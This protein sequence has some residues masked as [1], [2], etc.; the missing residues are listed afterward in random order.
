MLLV[1]MLV[2]RGDCLLL[3]IG[4]WLLSRPGVSKVLALLLLWVLLLLNKLWMLLPLLL[5]LLMTR[6]AQK[7]SV[8]K[9]L[10]NLKRMAVLLLLLL[11]IRVLSLVNPERIR[12]MFL[13]RG[14]QHARCPRRTRP[15]KIRIE[16][17][18]TLLLARLRGRILL[19]LLQRRRSG[20]RL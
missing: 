12:R 13:V 19:V 6:L 17:A 18:V 2:I 3:W 5:R 10:V 9:V 7:A 11:L 4:L 16:S 8:A 15:L 20:G 14:L 1:L